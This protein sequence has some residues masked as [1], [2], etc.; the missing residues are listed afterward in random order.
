MQQ[1][2]WPELIA[3]L[4]RSGLTQPQLAEA[5][6]CGQSTISE[7]LRGKT[8]DPRTSTGLVLLRLAKDRCGID[9][10]TLASAEQPQE[11]RDAA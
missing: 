4:I 2:P 6:G 1:I 11:V 3:G 10:E 5:A 7:L 9:V 8:T